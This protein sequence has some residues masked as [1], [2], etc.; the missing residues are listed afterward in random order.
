MGKLQ[1]EQFNPLQRSRNT[2]SLAHHQSSWL[3]TLPQPLN[4]QSLCQSKSQ[5]MF[6]QSDQLCPWFQSNI[7]KCLQLAPIFPLSRFIG[8]SLNPQEG[9]LSLPEKPCIHNLFALV[10]T[11]GDMNCSCRTPVQQKYPIWLSKSTSIIFN[12]HSLDNTKPMIKSIFDI[13]STVLPACPIN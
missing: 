12:I 13:P 10:W 11:L 3:P 8:L 2:Q 5:W 9:K 1:P 6:P 7:R 4:R